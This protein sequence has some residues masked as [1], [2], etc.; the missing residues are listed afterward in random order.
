MIKVEARLFAT[1]RRYRPEV[2]LKEP[3]VVELAQGSTVE[4]LWQTLGIPEDV[5]KQTFVNGLQADRGTT[6]HDG[7]RVGI[8]P[9][10]AGG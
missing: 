5:V 4:Q 2:S 3:I 7:D 1:L 10:I 8:F 9:P 6:L